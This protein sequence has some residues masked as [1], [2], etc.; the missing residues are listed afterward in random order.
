[1]WVV[2][3]ILLVERIGWLGEGGLDRMKWSVM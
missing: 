3:M 1:M 2:D